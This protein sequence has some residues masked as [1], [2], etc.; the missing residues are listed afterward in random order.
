MVRAEY[1][2][3]C[4]EIFFSPVC[5]RSRTSIPVLNLSLNSHRSDWWRLFLSVSN[6][7]TCE[8]LGMKFSLSL[9]KYLND[10][11]PEPPDTAPF[12]SPYLWGRVFSPAYVR[13]PSLSVSWPEVTVVPP[14]NPGSTF[15]LGMLRNKCFRNKYDFATG[16]FFMTHFLTDVTNAVLTVR[17]VVQKNNLE[18]NEL[19]QNKCLTV[20][21]NGI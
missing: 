17:C 10:F 9:L 3:Q 20:N 5:L 1:C 12:F 14:L 8:Q 18:K 6:P 21:K 19:N 7:F 11:T 2:Q 16:A 13:D 4:P 15:V